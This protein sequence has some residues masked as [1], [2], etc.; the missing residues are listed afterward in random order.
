MSD[1]RI[2]AIYNYQYAVAETR[3]ARKKEC[4]KEVS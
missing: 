4:K 1:E 3:V 2:M